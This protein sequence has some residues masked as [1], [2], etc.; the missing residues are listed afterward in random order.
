MDVS[1]NGS[2]L[3]EYASPTSAHRIYK[4]FDRIVCVSNQV[5][6]SFQRRFGPYSNI[7]TVHNPIPTTEVI[8]NS[9]LAPPHHHHGD[10]IELV[11]VG[12]LF[13]VKG[14]DRLI[15]A[16]AQA[17]AS[18]S[19]PFHLSILG[20]GPMYA[21]LKDQIDTYG[22]SDVITLVGFVSNPYPYIKAAS[23]LICSSRTEAFPLVIGES[24]ILGVPVL[25][26]RCAGVCEWLE[27]GC[28]GLIVE[29]S[30][31]G[32]LNG[33]QQILTMSSS[34]YHIWKARTNEKQRKIDF[35]L[36]IKYFEKEM[37]LK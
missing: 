1:E 6:E 4:Q 25:G 33:L 9:F 8:E 26:T 14:F 24:I 17:V 12:S 34:E 32:L 7:S 37:F 21:E 23:W 31:A 30:T 22:L 28:Y 2:K 3:K 13:P 18:G 20:D 19:P 16:C 10:R 29:N 5:A 27:N 35:N 36:Q 15:N 11:S